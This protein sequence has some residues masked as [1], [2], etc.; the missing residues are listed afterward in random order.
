MPLQ[1]PPLAVLFLLACFAASGDAQ[2]ES[3]FMRLGTR[4]S[5]GIS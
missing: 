4:V 5:N 1:V 2:K 3:A